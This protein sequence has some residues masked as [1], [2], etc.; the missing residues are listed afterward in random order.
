L[1][2]PPHVSPDYIV[3]LPR[4]TAAPF[5]LW[6][7]SEETRG[8]GI[9]RVLS[10]ALVFFDIDVSSADRIA[11]CSTHDLV[12]YMMRA[13]AVRARG[14]SRRHLYNIL[15]KP[16]LPHPLP[17]S[18][19]LLD[20]NHAT[21]LVR[22]TILRRTVSECALVPYA[23]IITHHLHHVQSAYGDQAQQRLVLRRLNLLETRPVEE[24]LIDEFM[25][26]FAAFLWHYLSIGQ[27]THQ[28][29][30]K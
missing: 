22:V 29:L 26:H 15:S 14:A 24:E 13:N 17:I 5:A 7:M 11:F 1:R 30:R 16:L 3:V 28:T 25:T 10:S 20:G 18:P 6:S 27:G 9:D 23:D 2:E 8:L 4:Y 21:P 19:L 12:T